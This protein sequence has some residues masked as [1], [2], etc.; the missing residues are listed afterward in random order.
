L[1]AGSIPPTFFFLIDRQKKKKIDRFRKMSSSSSSF[2]SSSL[3]WAQVFA[4]LENKSLCAAR[5]VCKEW[6][7]IGAQESQHATPVVTCSAPVNIAV[8]KYWGKR[9]EELILPLNSSL[10][11][12]LNQQDLRSTTSARASRHFKRDRLF[13]NGQEQEISYVRLQN[14]LRGV[15]ELASNVYSDGDGDGGRKILVPRS[16]WSSYHVHIVSE[17]NFPTAAGLASSASGYCALVYTLAKLYGVEASL[18]ELSAIARQGSGSACRSMFGGFAAWEM[19]TRDDGA[20]SRAVP[21]ADETHWP[22][23]EVLVLVVNAGEKDV[24]STV[25][26]RGEVRDNLLERRARD[27]VPERMRQMAAA[28][29]QRDMETF[30]ELTMADSD[31]FHNICHNTVPPLHYMNDVSRDIQRLLRAFNGHRGHRHAAYTYDAGPNA[32]VYLLRDELV[33]FL[34]LVLHYFPKGVQVASSSSDGDQE[35]F[36]RSRAAELVDRA[37]A[38]QLPTDLIASIDAGHG[39]DAPVTVQPSTLAYILHTNLGPGAQRL[40]NSHSVF[41][42]V[43]IL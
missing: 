42:S 28:I 26:M 12:T 22:D 7:D 21:I 17:N 13:L 4:Y 11:G 16:A 39:D 24:G 15:R 8:V 30:A 38:C 25:G 23:M 32:V 43:Q 6:A 31:N 36:V 1:V 33:P 10:S 40:D 19:G 20:D 5:L 18:E 14:V 3:I 35:P 41:D 29:E 37:R 27:I 34:A 2:S 9:N